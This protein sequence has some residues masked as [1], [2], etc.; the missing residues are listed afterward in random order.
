MTFKVGDAVCYNDDWFLRRR[1][2]LLAIEKRTEFIVKAVGDD[3]VMVSF[4]EN[5]KTVYQLLHSDWLQLVEPNKE[6]GGNAS[7]PASSQ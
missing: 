2:P 6:T 5:G 4:P 7:E 3:R 1:L